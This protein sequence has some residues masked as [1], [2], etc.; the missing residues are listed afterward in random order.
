METLRR[1]SL[2]LWDQYGLLNF[3]GMTIFIKWPRPIVG[4]N[5]AAVK[6]SE[7]VRELVGYSSSHEIYRRPGDLLRG[8]LAFIGCMTCPTSKKRSDPGDRDNQGLGFNQRE[9]AG[10]S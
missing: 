3:A 5:V 1:G 6:V 10:T 4:R 2:R 7:E 8:A 9:S